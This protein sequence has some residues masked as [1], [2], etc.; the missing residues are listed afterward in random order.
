MAGWWI[1]QEK[2]AEMAGW[3]IR[4]EKRWQYEEVLRVWGT[5]GVIPLFKLNSVILESGFGVR[6]P[7]SVPCYYVTLT[8]LFSG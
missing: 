6:G 5:R 3:W 4:Q 2:K 8:S 7:S 1:R